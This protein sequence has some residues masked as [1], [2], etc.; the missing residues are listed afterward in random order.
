MAD[1]EEFVP[2]RIW[3]SEYPVRYA[4]AR[5]RARMTVLR[6]GNGRL[7]VHSPC[8][9]NEATAA[10]IAGLGEVA[11]IIAPG[12]YHYFHVASCQRAFPS[13]QTHICPGI[14]RKRPD[15]SF[16]WVLGNRPHPDWAAE[17]EQVFV[18]GTRFMSEVAFFDR[19]SR[20]LLLVDLIENIGDGTPGTDI[21]LRFWWKIVM[22]M[23]NR[24][25]PAPEYQ[26][27][28]GRKDI[29][30]EALERILAW[31][32]ERVVVAHGDLIEHDARDIL[33]KAWEKPLQRS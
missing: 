24:A 11:H 27:G 32:F 14:E 30:A 33:R 3:L 8:E 19:P 17:L 29:V 1:L 4:G 6:L 25:L 12:T 23:W 31:D 20:T 10:Q 5:F 26:F 2:G 15:L 21:V 9:L 7:L 16:D 22:R 18:G 28:W 13:A